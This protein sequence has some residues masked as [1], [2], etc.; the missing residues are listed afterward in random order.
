MRWLMAFFC[1]VL[2]FGSVAEA[3]DGR[4]LKV[5]PQFLDQDGRQA[6]SPSLYDRDAYQAFLRRNPAKRSGLRFAVQWKAHTADQLKLRVEM[7][8]VAQSDQT[9]AT[10][11][12][13][14]V[15][16]HHWFSH[17]AYL[18]LRDKAYKDFGEVTAWRVTLWD[19]DQLLSEQ[20]SFLW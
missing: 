15:Q 3:A 10:T 5:L 18:V 19:G 17:W 4:V 9:R 11:I 14:P 7:R 12:E 2:I 8:G 16:Q 6:L 1:W 20:K 13:Q